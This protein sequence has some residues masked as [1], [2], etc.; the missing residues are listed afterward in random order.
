[1]ALGLV[2]MGTAGTTWEEKELCFWRQQLNASGSVCGGLTA[3]PKNAALGPD[4]IY[5]CL[6]LKKTS[7]CSQCVFDDV[8]LG[9]DGL[10]LVL[11]LA[12]PIAR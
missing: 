6:N 9:Y 3:R 4:I 11:A 12:V 8:L 1:M 7:L 10:P 2:L 5:K